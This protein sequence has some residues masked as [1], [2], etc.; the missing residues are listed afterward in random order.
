M[1][2]EDLFLCFLFCLLC[3]CYGDAVEC[4]GL[5][6]VE[7][8]QNFFHVLLAHLQFLNVSNIVEAELRINY[9]LYIE[10]YIS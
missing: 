5:A 6:V 7:V 8:G 10:N 9:F 3:S 1:F 2:K 4:E